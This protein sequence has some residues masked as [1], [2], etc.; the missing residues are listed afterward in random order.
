MA[1]NL[2]TPIDSTWSS[3]RRTALGLVAALLASGLLDAGAEACGFPPD[4]LPP[5]S[6]RASCSNCSADGGILVCDCLTIGQVLN[7]TSLDITNCKTDPAN[8]NGVLVCDPCTTPSFGACCLGGASC[9]EL[10]ASECSELSGTYQGDDSLCEAVECSGCDAEPSTVTW[11]GDRA[12]AFSDA[13]NWEPPRVPLADEAAGRCDEVWIRGG[14]GL[15]ID[16][17]AEAAPA[18]ALA[19]GTAP[20]PIRRTHRLTVDAHRL[21]QPIDGTI[22]GVTTSPVAGERSVEVINSAS[23]LLNGGGVLARHLG[24]G[25]V[26][27][28]AIEVVSPRGYLETTGRFGLGIEGPGSLLVRDRATVKAAEMVIGEERA[29]GSVTVRGEE[30]TLETGSIAVGF[31]D[32]G[33]LLVEEGAVVT[34][35]AGRIDFNL[36]GDSRGRVTV[37]GEDAAGNPSTWRAASLDVYPRGGVAVEEAGLVAIE[38]ALKVGF[39]GGSADCLYGRAC[40]TVGARS[41]L[42]VGSLAVGFEGGAEVRILA[43]ETGGGRILVD[44]LTVIGATRQPARL[45]L[46]GLGFF[47][48]GVVIAPSQSSVGTLSVSTGAEHAIEGPLRVGEGPS[49]LGTL[50]LSRPDPSLPVPELTVTG[51]TSFFGYPPPPGAERPVSAVLALSPGTFGSDR[52]VVIEGTGLLDCSD[53]RVELEAP[54]RLVNRGTIR[55]DLFVLGDYVQEE[56]GV[57]EGLVVAQLP[58]IGPARSLGLAAAVPPAPAFEPII[59]TGDA[60]LAGKAKLQFGNGAAPRQGDAFELLQVAGEV[61][62][63]FDEVEIAGLAPGF[64]FASEIVNR[65]LVLTSLTDAEPLPYVNLAGKPLLLESKK[66]AKLKLT[67][68]GDTSASLTVAYTVAGTAESGVDFVAL[69][70]TIQ[71][72]ARKKSVTLLVQPIA[73]ALDEGSETIE[74]ALAPNASFAPGLVSELTLELRDGKTK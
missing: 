56:T 57:V 37:G 14:Q 28:G 45:L 1:R 30:S 48:G 43:D 4:T 70:G 58:P 60:T 51:G 59:V 63:A 41:G 55:G 22:E 6:Y 36:I 19:G 74:I 20:T 17:D 68:S 47:G 46:R 12:G 64:D 27:Q 72:P 29:D 40:V 32:D 2:A 3:W 71:F 16:L 9:A 10:T 65:A 69:P 8:T 54:A 66:A 21:L 42:S 52:D 5:G 15:V 18:L 44:G 31:Q 24:V 26:G 38:G 7:R 61:T 53:G 67:R 11:V 35:E 23:L 34:S 25:S 39:E 73:D 33:T 50:L 49:S 13:Q 62:G